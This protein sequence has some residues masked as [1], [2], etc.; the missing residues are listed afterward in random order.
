M[1]AKL[2]SAQITLLREL[3]TFGA[4]GIRSVKNMNTAV[5]LRE[6]GLLTQTKIDKYHALYVFVITKDGCEAIGLDY[7]V[8]MGIEAAVEA[9]PAPVPTVET[10]KWDGEGNP[11]VGDIVVISGDWGSDDIYALITAFEGGKCWF[12]DVDKDGNLLPWFDDNGQ[13]TGTPSQFYIDN[14]RFIF[15]YADP[16]PNRYNA[17]YAPVM[18]LPFD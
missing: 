12:I 13:Q 9:H 1:A 6:K 15:P 14:M 16:I 5:A 3:A 4:E 7:N 8:V 10:H 17:C 11:N 18:P 2:S